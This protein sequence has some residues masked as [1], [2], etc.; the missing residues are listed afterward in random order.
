MNDKYVPEK[1]TKY[2]PIENL[3]S[4]E[5]LLSDKIMQTRYRMLC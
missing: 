5:N 2:Y 4:K 1:I 3:N